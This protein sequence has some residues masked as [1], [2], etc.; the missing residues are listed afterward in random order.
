M[1]IDEAAAPGG[2]IRRL[3]PSDLPAFQAHLLRL[4]ARS[5][6]ERF[7]HAVN[8]AWLADYSKSC[9]GLEAIT[10]GFFETGAIRGAG[11]LR[12][13]LLSPRAGGA[14]AAFS[15]EPAYRHRGVGAALMARIL[16]AAGNRRLDRLN[17]YCLAQNRAMLGLARKFTDELRFETDAVSGRL[18][19]RLPSPLSLWGEVFDDSAGFAAACVSAQRRLFDAIAHPS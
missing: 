16:R 15:V 13:G 2:S 17:L 19:A 8:D 1:M 5:R 3:W 11:E 14:E 4:D 18:V 9:F 12:T 7:G 10:Y 6:H